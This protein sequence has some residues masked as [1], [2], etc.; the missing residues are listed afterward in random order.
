[1]LFFQVFAEFSEHG[2]QLPVLEDR[3]VIQVGWLAAQ[4]DK[5]MSRIKAI[6]ARSI[7]PLV[8][9]NRLIGDHN[10]DMMNVG[11]HGGC[12][13]GKRAGHAVAVIVAGDRL[14]FVH[15]SRIADAIIEATV[16]QRD[17]SG[18]LLL[19][20]R[21]DRFASPRGHTR[22]ILL[23][24]FAQV[25]VQFG[26]ASHL[27]NGRGPTSLQVL[28]AILDVRLLVAASRHAE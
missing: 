16:G 12:L 9:S 23:T 8:P 19:E 13:E 11:F 15:R 28:D 2:R 10:F 5:I 14:V 6:F 4:H 17:R 1:M 24:T 25:G 20:T 26:H 7:T 18:S 3:R 27:R 21:A 22:E